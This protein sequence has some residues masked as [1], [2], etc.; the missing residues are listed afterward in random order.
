M[1]NPN[2]FINH[3]TPGNEYSTGW[4]GVASMANGYPSQREKINP[5]EFEKP[6]DNFDTIASAVVEYTHCDLSGK[7]GF[8]NAIVTSGAERWYPEI[9]ASQS[10]AREGFENARYE[11]WKQNIIDLDAQTAVNKY[12]RGKTFDALKKLHNYLK[13]GQDAPTQAE[14]LSNCFVDDKDGFDAAIDQLRYNRHSD[15]D[16]MYYS[17]R[18]EKL[19]LEEPIDADGRLYLNAEPMDAFD[20]AG[21]FVDACKETGLPYEFKINRFPDRSDAIVFYIDNKEIGN[22]TNI[23][24]RILDENPKINQRVGRPPLLSEKVTDKIGYG[25]ETGGA[26]Y[27]ERQCKKFQ[28]AIEDVVSSYRGDSL[29]GSMQDRAKSLYYNRHEAFLNALR[30]KLR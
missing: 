13:S 29:Q 6:S 10:M 1:S 4:E 18:D 19:G 16:W 3:E 9:K 2:Q 27:S 28:E 23:L 21:K 17:S 25:D 8:Y 20:I 22:Y 30:S 15:S 26:S 24:S 7:N 5:S 12:G 14:L 11:E